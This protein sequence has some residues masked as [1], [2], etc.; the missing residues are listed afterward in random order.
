MISGVTRS[1]AG[2]ATIAT[3]STLGDFLWANVIPEH[4]PL[5]GIAHGTILFACIGLYLGGPT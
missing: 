4:R 2:A 3:V 1:L 5:Y